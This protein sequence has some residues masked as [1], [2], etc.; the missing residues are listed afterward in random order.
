M[1]ERKAIGVFLLFSASIVL[2]TCQLQ[3]NRSTGN[4][5]ALQVLNNK[6]LAGGASVMVTITQGATTIAQ[7]TLPINGKTS[8]DFSFS[9]SSSGT[10]QVSA[11]LLDGS[12]NVLSQASTTVKIPMGNYPVVLTLASSSKA[13]TAF[14]IISPVTATG[15]ITGTAIAVTVPFGTSV[16]AMVATFT[17]TG[18][19]VSVSATGVQQSG[20][21]ANNFT[22][23]VTYT[24]T[25]TD[26]ST[27]NYTVTVT[28]QAPSHDASLSSAVLNGYS[29]PTGTY[30]F[31]P[32]F[33]PTIYTYTSVSPEPY[34]GDTPYSLVL[35]TLA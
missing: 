20:T 22:N 27:Q 9:L 29:S 24:V 8:V 16:T 18:V 15:T 28:V 11:Q 2:T 35:L 13:I 10:Y 33:S 4:N 19:S 21:T 5:L 14:S 12:G 3:F 32:A 25:A 26:G 34:Y 31:V 23:P 30:A 7:Q 6:S 1:H 17:T